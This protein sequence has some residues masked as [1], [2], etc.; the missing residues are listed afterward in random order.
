M[1]VLP[2]V[3]VFMLMLVLTKYANPNQNADCSV[4][5]AQ[6]MRLNT[7]IGILDL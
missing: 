4:P 7:Q 2:I 3:V 5:Y 6:V 1:I